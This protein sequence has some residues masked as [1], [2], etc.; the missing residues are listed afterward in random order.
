MSSGHS[1]DVNE[2][3]GPFYYVGEA[4]FEAWGFT[5]PS[6]LTILEWDKGSV[7]DGEEQLDG[8]HQSVYE[9]FED[10]RK[11]CTGRVDWGISPDQFGRSLHTDTER[12]EVDE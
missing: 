11:I 9:S 8:Y 6:G 12:S 10:M 4:G 7:P 3:V 1:S 2:R 5:F